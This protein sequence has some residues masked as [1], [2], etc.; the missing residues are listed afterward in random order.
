MLLVFYLY[1][2]SRIARYL[3]IGLTSFLLLVTYLEDIELEIIGVFVT[4]PENRV[5][6]GLGAVL[7]LAEAT[8][9]GAGRFRDGLREELRCHEV[10]AAAGGEVTAVLHEL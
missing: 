1:Q 2:Q 3:Y 7:D 6:A 8:M 4:G 9:Y 5:I 10:A